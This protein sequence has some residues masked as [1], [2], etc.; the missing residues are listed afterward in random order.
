MTPAH[1]TTPAILAARHI[2]KGD[3]QAARAELANWPWGNAFTISE[4]R[5]I[6][7]ACDEAN[8]RYGCHLGWRDL[9]G[10]PNTCSCGEPLRDGTS[11][12]R[13]C[14]ELNA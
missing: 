3:V 13:D 7:G 8:R 6:A 2:V 12:C 4:A 9:L 1:L 14:A 11:M 5:A 10:W